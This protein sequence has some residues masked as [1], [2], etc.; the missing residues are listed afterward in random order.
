MSCGIF[1]CIKYSTVLNAI[2]T[3]KCKKYKV[4]SLLVTAGK[5]TDLDLRLAQELH[6]EFEESFTL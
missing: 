4:K 6:V 3:L 1:Q 5:F 2:R